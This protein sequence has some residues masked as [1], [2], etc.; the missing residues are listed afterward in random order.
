M[1][2]FNSE[3]KYEQTAMEWDD[4]T[5]NEEIFQG[6]KIGKCIPLMQRHREGEGLHI[7]WKIVS[8]GTEVGWRGPGHRNE[9][10]WAVRAKTAY[11]SGD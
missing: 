5:K 1:M 9:G 2:V 6:D 3:Q 11:T 7:M 8:L 10:T 4:L